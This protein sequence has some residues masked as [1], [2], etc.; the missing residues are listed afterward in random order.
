MK[1]TTA[2]QTKGATCTPSK[3]ARA[4]GAEAQHGQGGLDHR[5]R[6]H[7]VLKWRS[8]QGPRVLRVTTK[9]HDMSRTMPP[10]SYPA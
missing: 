4:A 7:A 8:R 2:M 1:K 5:V 6:T 10:L 9:G 3:A